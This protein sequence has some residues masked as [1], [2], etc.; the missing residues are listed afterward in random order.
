MDYQ[1]TDSF[2][3]SYT[4]HKVIFAG[5]DRLKDFHFIAY[6]V[7][8]ATHVFLYNHNLTVYSPAG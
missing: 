8:S 2:S 4:S 6:S 3:M 7:M 5:E 1:P